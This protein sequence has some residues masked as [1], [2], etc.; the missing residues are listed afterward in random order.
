[1]EALAQHHHNGTEADGS[2]NDQ[3]NPRE[4][5][6][7]LDLVPVDHGPGYRV[8]RACS[9]SPDWAVVSATIGRMGD[10]NGNLVAAQSDGQGALILKIE[11]VSVESSS[12]PL[13][14]TPTPEGEPQSS[15][16]SGTRPPHPQQIMSD[17]SA[18][19]AEFDKRMSVLRQVIEAG[20]ITQRPVPT[21]GDG[22]DEQLAT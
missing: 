2:R 12:A 21:R 13:A 5:A 4:R 18:L 15:A 16:G 22:S 19:L 10:I 9:L 20:E 3:G 7:I 1:M 11:G 14:K 6:V 17:Y 8:A